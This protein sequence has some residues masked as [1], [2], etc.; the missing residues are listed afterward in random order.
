MTDHI[1][2][3]NEKAVQEALAF[4]DNMPTPMPGGWGRPMS[5]LAAAV[6][7]RNAEIEAAVR[8]GYRRCY[9]A[10]S[11]DPSGLYIG[12]ILDEAVAA[13]KAEKGRT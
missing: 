4:A 3:V 7:A 13:W 8:F 1:G 5:T 12:R 2:D 10:H 9:D 11:H 6:R